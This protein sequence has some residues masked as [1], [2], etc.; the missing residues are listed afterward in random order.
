MD[1]FLAMI[2]GVAVGGLFS[3]IYTIQVR[4]NSRKDKEKANILR[5]G[6]RSYEQ[7]ARAWHRDMDALEQRILKLTE[8]KNET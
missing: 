3:G 8:D 4:E 6:A 2:V 7:R 1:I 5:R